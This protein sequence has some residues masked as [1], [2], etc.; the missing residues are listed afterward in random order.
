MTK[1]KD[2]SSPEETDSS[3]LATISP[4]KTEGTV[5]VPERRVRDVDSLNQVI[6]RIILDDE[7][8]AKHR[9][10]VQESVDGKPPFNQGYLEATGQEG[11]CNLNFGDAKKRVK[12][13]SAGYY[14]LTESVPCIALI[15][16]EYGEAEQVPERTEWNA[17]LSEEFDKMLKSW[18]QFNSYF[19]L[20][21]QKFVTHGVGFLYF[22]DNKDWR[23]EVAGLEDFK[24]P[25]GVGLSEDD[26][27]I[28]MVI[29]EVPVA[30]LYSWVRNAADTDARW[31]KKEVQN[32]I[33]NA[34]DPGVPLGPESWEKW[35]EKMKNNDLFASVTAKSTVTIVYAWTREFSGKV[36]QFITLRN[37]TNKDFLFKCYDAF[38][39][40]NE[41]FNFFPYEVG[42]NGTL[43]SVRGEAHDIYARVQV[44]TNLK[45]QT[46]DNAKLSGSLILQPT[47][48]TAAEDMAILFFA[49]AAYLPPGVEVKNATLAN[50]STNILP[51]LQDMSMGINGDVN[52]RDPRASQQEKTKF[53]VHRDIA[54]ESVLPTAAMAMF[55]QPWGRHLYEVCKRMIK[56]DSE[57]KNN[58]V[59][60]GVPKEV[61]SAPY[62]VHPYRAL[63]LGSPTQRMAA[64]DGL[65]RFWGSLDPI[66]QNNLL[67]DQFAQQVT[68]GQVDRYVP[69]A[70][71]GGRL[72]ID[73]E[74]AE[75]QNI[76]M[77][78]GQE[79]T[80]AGND[81]HI[82]HLGSHFPS[83]DKDLTLMESGQGTPSILNVVHIKAAHSQKH[84]SML[85][86]DEL[87]KAVVA[88]LARVF[89]NLTERVTA[90]DK[91]A[92]AA[93]AKEAQDSGQQ[94]S[95]K[96]Q[97]MM[98]DAQVARQIK[99]DDAALD[100]QLRQAAAAQEQAI[101][102]AQ[103]AS[104]LN[105]DAN[106]ARLTATAEAAGKVSGAIGAVNTQT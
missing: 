55:Y 97:N 76:A 46:V 104:R 9:V 51:V 34:S 10:C 57:F 40:V 82:V 73:T 91:A 90:A 68:Y 80:V 48:E 45:C 43:H 31:N 42:T 63:G 92:E 44:M 77:E 100:R 4:G 29:R 94:P 23:W 53:E 64:L 39:S 7:P 13:I 32:A 99:I 88:E 61:F 41:C 56:N 93:T 28:A 72:P 37:K 24:L 33:M 25:R 12:L 85:K 36:S 66:G 54:Q 1:P 84:M 2:S 71:T 15:E 79:V 11:R 18:K 86:P 67:R 8:A 52:T 102:D 20:L 5:T 27:D 22:C 38:A 21:V 62:C 47:T 70:Q 58:C 26:C 83:L 81:N 49:G 69:R 95:A 101:K 50:P 35:Q 14:D 74:I 30:K 65:M 96:Q 89:N 103:E 16:T 19:Q 3:G 6:D 17:I 106:Y 75:L 59:A 105:A 60:R 98:A 87:N 78:S